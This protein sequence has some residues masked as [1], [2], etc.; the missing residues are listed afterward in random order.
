MMCKCG[1]KEA[2]IHSP[3][4]GFICFVCA[5]NKIQKELGGD[6]KQNRGTKNE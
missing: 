5:T 3:S 4:E 1:K 6:D 2:T